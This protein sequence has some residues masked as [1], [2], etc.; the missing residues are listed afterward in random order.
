MCRKVRLGGVTKHKQV[1]LVLAALVLGVAL[2][3]GAARADSSSSGWVANYQ[4]DNV[5][6]FAIATTNHPPAGG[7]SSAAV[8]ADYSSPGW[9]CYAPISS[10]PGYLA[11]DRLWYAWRNNAWTICNESGWIIN[12]NYVTALSHSRS[13][14]TAICGAT[15]YATLSAGWYWRDGWRGG[16][17]WSGYHWMPS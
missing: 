14:D 12:Q 1:M 15:W 4:D 6:V 17:S 5:C 3:A 16:G 9:Q 8:E 7:V 2:A 11:L 13:F 10:P